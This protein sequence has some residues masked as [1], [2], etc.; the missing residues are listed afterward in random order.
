MS[1][2]RSFPIRYDRWRPFFVVLGLGPRRSFVELS[3]D[4]LDVRMGWAFNARI[5]RASIRTA[6]RRGNIWWAIGVHTDFRGTWLVNGALSGIVRLELRDATRGRSGGVPITI[7][8]LGLGLED[9]DGFL[10]ALGSLRCSS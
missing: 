1:P 6:Q 10:E 9:P 7:R 2:P 3:D 5:P 8:R 4:S